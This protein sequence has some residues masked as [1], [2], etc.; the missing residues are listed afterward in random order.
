MHSGNRPTLRDVARESGLSITQTSRALNGHSDVAAA[1]RERALAAARQLGYVPNLEARRLKS[2]GT[3]SQSIGLVLVT[4]TQRFS[5]PFFGELLATMVDEAA[6]N[7]YELQLSAPLADEDPVASYERAIRAKRVDGFVVLRTARADPRVRYLNDHG[8]PFV[9][10]GRIDD[11]GRYPAVGES[12]DC[13]MPA[14][15]HLVELGH[16]RIGCLIEPLEYAISARRH[17]SFRRA[18]DTRGLSYE[19]RLVLSGGFREDSGF[20][21]AGRLL[22]QAAPPTA[23]VA[24]NDLLAFG[25]IRAAAVRN[26][27]VPDQLSIV[28]FDDISASR[29]TS[30]P[31]TTLRHEDRII[32][33]QLIVQL[34]KAIDEP[35][36]TGDV[37][38]NP[39]L[40][41]R[42]STAAPP[43][44]GSIR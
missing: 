14:I 29:F 2:P 22:D 26:I 5:D 37:L 9:M 3:R 21:A 28:G 24:F 18:L 6:A 4:G 12:I 40:V 36:S 19:E 43:T 41:V 38:L 17:E 31:L 27:V 42:D 23:L 8:F 25:A 33:R 30:P 34:L 1:T 35:E 16:H 39:E 15:D 32:G 11:E 44:G 7:G 20:E 10:F 13:L